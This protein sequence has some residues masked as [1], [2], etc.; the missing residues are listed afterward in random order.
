MEHQKKL[1]LRL[2]VLFVFS[3]APALAQQIPQPAAANPNLEDADSLVLPDGTPIRVR[4]VKGFSSTN[5][6]VGDAV[7]FA[8]VF[9]IR[10]NGAVVIPRR[11]SFV[12]KIVSVN[13][14]RRGVRDAQVGV[15]Y[16]PLTLPTGE[17]A[18]V[19]PVLKTHANK[20]AKVAEGTSNAIASAAGLFITAG[21]PLLVL[22]EK[23]E[24]QVLPEGTVETFYLNGPL[25][26]S[27]KAVAALQ[28]S[29][30]SGH[31]YIYF[32][33]M[34]GVGRNSINIP[35]LFCGEWPLYGL[36]Q[37]ELELNPGTYWFSTDY[38]KDRPIRLDALPDHEYIFG[39]TK[40]GLFAKEIPASYISTITKLTV[41]DWTKLT[42]EDYRILTA[43]PPNKRNSRPQHN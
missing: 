5:A 39:R 42:P 14:P 33:G 28:P 3:I 36:Y 34:E 12:A 21:I 31:A 13:R 26:V 43:E 16:E 38:A 20:A 30:A 37:T 23:G 11:T 19:R 17:T 1:A 10:A 25:R 22:F 4:V 15:I 29:T 24:E 32:T 40:H 18:T 41:Q 6:K 7:N 35:K 27:R 2:F 9:E 8:V